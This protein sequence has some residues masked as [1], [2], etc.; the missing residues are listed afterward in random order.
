MQRWTFAVCLAVVA[1]IAINL[2]ASELDRL[3]EQENQSAGVKLQPVPVVGDHIFLRRIYVDLIGR[4]PTEAEVREFAS[5]PARAAARSWSTS[6][7]KTSGLPIAGR[8]STPT[9]C[10]CARKPTGGAAL[11]AYVHNAVKTGMPYDE[12][13][14]QADLHQR[15]GGQDARS[16]A[17]SWAT[18][19]IRWR[20][21]ASPRRCSWACGWAVPSATTIRSTCGPAAI[22]TT[23]PPSTARRAA[24][25]SQL[26]NVVYATEMEQIGHPLAARRGRPPRPTASRS[27][28][29][30]RSRWKRCR[31]ARLTSSGWKRSVPR[32]WRPKSKEDKGPVDRRPAG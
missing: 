15:Q 6:S 30:S 18:T 21:P 1:S 8:S 12:M 28:P 26:T 22:F 3:I 19:P 24:I 16:R 23:W 31:Q 27:P 13:C 11:I 4:I 29:S 9:C 32:S 20:W 7:C 17:S 10:G 14:P 5:W 2:R 25:E